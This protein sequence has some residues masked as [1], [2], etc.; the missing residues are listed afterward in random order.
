M[1][2]FSLIV[3]AYN[4]EKNVTD[5]LKN[6]LEIKGDIS[7]IIVVDDYSQD[8]T[9][10]IVKQHQNKYPQIILVKNKYKKGKAGALLTGAET[11]TKNWLV[12][13]DCDAIVDPYALEAIK[14]IKDPRVWVVG[15]RAIKR[16]VGWELIEWIRMKLWP[17]WLTRGQLMLVKNQKELLVNLQ[18]VD[19]V[20]IAFRAI[21][22]NKKVVNCEQMLF[23]DS[24]QTGWD[25][26]RQLWRRVVAMDKAIWQ[27]WLLLFD[28]RFFD[29]NDLIKNLLF[30][31]LGIMLPI[32]ICVAIIVSLVFYWQLI[33][34]YIL[35]Y[36]LTLTC[37]VVAVAT[38]YS[39]VT[40]HD[41]ANLNWKK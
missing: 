29:I 33:L 38:V 2:G 22:K 16:K 17:T 27:Y 35:F 32:V 3:C 19:D 18:Y 20:E 36:P 31:L 10:E 7:E 12:L 39:Y 24:F 34:A 11:A 4:E 41:S 40:R 23:A 30:V 15:S 21:E 5:K 28:E 14:K 13:S 6:S 25:F 8:R 1:D 26:Y 37:F 9:A